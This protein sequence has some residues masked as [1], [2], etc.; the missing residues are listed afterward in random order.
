M[1]VNKAYK[2]RIYP[3]KDQAILI[4]KTIGCSPFVCNFFLGKQ[5]EIN[6]KKE[7][8]RLLTVGTTGIA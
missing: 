4:N 1:L 7:A 5:K 8:I 3:N 6:L 2:F